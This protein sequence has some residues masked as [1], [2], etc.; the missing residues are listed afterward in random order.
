MPSSHR[1]DPLLSVAL[2]A[3]AQAQ[4]SVV[5]AARGILLTSYLLAAIRDA[6][7]IARPPTP[8]VVSRLV[9]ARI[10]SDHDRL[11]PTS[12]LAAEPPRS[13]DPLIVVAGSGLAGKSR[14]VAR[15]KGISLREFM[16]GLY[17][18]ADPP[19]GPERELIEI[20]E[21]IA[22]MI[23]AEFARLLGDDR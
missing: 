22:A 1:F 16:A 5:V 2:T 23:D 20:A 18:Q 14:A 4:A 12:P 7:S 6:T 9:I 8:Q 13:G 3:E 19:G 10:E 11:G 17:L 15:S 21:S